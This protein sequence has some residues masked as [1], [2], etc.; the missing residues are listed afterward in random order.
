[1][2]ISEI[3]YKNIGLDEI[4]MS[5]TAVKSRVS[6]LS[7]VTV[8]IEFELVVQ[9]FSENAHPKKLTSD[10][11]YDEYVNDSS[12]EK[13]RADIKDF[14]KGTY[15]SLSNILTELDTA[16]GHYQEWKKDLWDNYVAENYDDW[17]MEYTD[18]DSDIEDQ[19]YLDLFEREKYDDFEEDA[20]SIKNWL[21]DRGLI[22]MSNWVKKYDITWPYLIEPDH[23][24]M[25][26]YEDIA[27][28]FQKAV[29]MDVSYA[30]AYHKG[31]RPIDS[32]MIEPDS[33]IRPDNA[34]D[35]FG[36]EFISPPL[37]LEDAIEQIKQVKSWAQAG[38]AY[39]NSTT[40]LHMNISLPGYSIDNLDYIKLVLFLGDKWI[41]D[42]FKRSSN[43]YA[44]SSID[45]INQRISKNLDL[46]PQALEKMRQGFNNLASKIIHQDYTQKTL[47]VSML[48][49]RVE[50]RA[51]GN[52]W[53]DMNLNTV[54]NTLMHNVDVLNLALDPQKENREYTKKLYK[55]LSPANPDAIKLFVDYQKGEINKDQLKRSWAEQV[56][57]F[58]GQLKRQQTGST[59]V[60]GDILQSYMRRYPIIKLPEGE[61]I[62]E[63]DA[64]NY[65]IAL[66]QAFK[67]M[68]D[69][70]L[71]GTSWYL[72]DSVNPNKGRYYNIRG[73]KGDFNGRPNEFKH[74][75][76][77]A[78]PR[79]LYDS[80]S[81]NARKYNVPDWYME[82]A[83][84]E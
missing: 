83:L 19:P 71:L 78:N 56:L 10:Y 41:L 25:R 75:M 43:E 40:G 59:K 46:L 82:P 13:L 64:I 35:D 57:G 20:G 77:S 42:Q 15:N 73:Q 34:T 9:N 44:R 21:E 81:D 55:L 63:I 14:F 54:V 50:F 84:D 48:D 52:N 58:S 28:S 16:Y 45:F 18:D 38:N 72:Y 60:A 3:S 49:N 24:H 70:N 61:I 79:E 31:D 51:P 67:F 32:Y 17:H 4:K 22:L 8:G 39:T 26:G 11:S 36:L 76:Y 7:G 62:S 30:T 65:D 5:P 68:K 80:F 27:D 69:Q 1:M 66:K 2:K 29:G 23:G 6:Q 53:L 33:S 37:P 47:S 12:W 74:N